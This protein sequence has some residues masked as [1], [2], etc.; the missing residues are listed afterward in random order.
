MLTRKGAFFFFF[1]F[2]PVLFFACD[3][4]NLVNLSENL[5]KTS[6]IYTREKKIT[7]SSSKNA[8]ICQD[9]PILWCSQSGDHLKGNLPKCGYM[10]YI[11][12]YK[13]E[14][15]FYILGYLFEL[16][17]YLEQLW[18]LFFFFVIWQTWAIFSM[19]NPMYRLKSCFSS[20]NLSIFCQ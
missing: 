1:S 8:K 14:G 7:F 16:T 11:W 4:E 15:S 3:V 12:K 2:F 19:K 13:N 5:S 17:K 20:R 6:W 18:K 9:N 10:S